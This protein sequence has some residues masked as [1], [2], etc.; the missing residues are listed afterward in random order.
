V[1]GTDRRAIVSSI[2]G[3][4][5]REPSGPPCKLSKRQT[6][7]PLLHHVD[8]DERLER[9]NQDGRP[10][11]SSLTGDVEAPVITID[12]VDVRMKRR[13]EHRAVARRPAAEGMRRGIV[14]RQVSLHFNDAPTDGAL[15]RLDAEA[16]AD[17]PPR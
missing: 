14:V 1:P 15:R 13:T 2:Y 4:R 16:E 8:A 17:Q 9:P 6:A 10:N 7:A 11:T 12:E 3:K 5:L